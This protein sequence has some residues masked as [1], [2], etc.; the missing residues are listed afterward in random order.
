MVDQRIREALDTLGVRR[1]AFAIHDAS[2]PSDPDEDLGV[3]SP[4]TRAAE[5][6]LAFV[7]ALGFTAIQLGPAGL[8]SRANASPYDGTAFSRTL[9]AIPARAYLEGELAGLVPPAQIAAQVGDGGARGDHRRGHDVAGALVEVAHAAL[10]GGARPELGPRFA[11]FVRT[12]PWLEADALCAVL[13]EVHGGEPW[14]WPTLDATLWVDDAPARIARRAALHRE[15]AATIERYA[16]GQWI[17]HLEH[18]RVQARARALGLALFADLQIGYAAGDRWSH[19]GAFLAD[20]VMG[21][22]PSRT[23]PDGQPWGYPVHDPDKLPGP[24]LDLVCARIGKLFAEYDGV[25]IDHPHGLVCPWVYRAG[26]DAATVRAGARLRESPDLVDH[27]ALARYAIARPEQLDRARPRHADGWVR[28]LD[29]AQVARYAVVV[30]AIVALAR[31]AGRSTEDLSCEVLSTMPTPLERVLARH[32][33]GRW[34][35]GQ[36]ANLADPTDVYRSENAQPADWVMLGNHDTPSIFAVIAGL[37]DERRAA[38][39]AHLGERLALSPA[40]RGALAD[41][42]RPGVLAAAM[43]GELLASRAEHAM[44]FFADLF[45]YEERFNTPGTY[46]DD[47]WSLRLPS[48]FDEVYRDRLAAGRALDLRLA[49]AFALG[50][51]GE[52]AR[53]AAI[54]PRRG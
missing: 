23:N 27:P 43:L 28:E 49:L 33:L 42:A 18:A 54:D 20:Y 9:T 8:T 6:L 7:R 30:D 52:R 31:A 2:F 10:R 40:D 1:L 5:R 41:R 12:Q 48:T 34:R 36:K 25:R 39:I 3:G 32:G 21:A 14:T 35:V 50:A 47:N 11:E 15:H 44:V 17:A 16:F 22:P 38:W 46:H 26:G 37:T 53:A 4:G 45:G 51:R 13:R 19:P 24:A 29:D